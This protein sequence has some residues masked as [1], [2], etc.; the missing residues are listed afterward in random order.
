MT[1]VGAGGVSITSWRSLT[2]FDKEYRKLDPVVQGRVDKALSKLVQTPMPPGI[3]FEK[4]KGYQDP[5]IY[6]IH[7]TGNFKV[8]FEIDGS[9]AVLRRVAVHDDIDLNP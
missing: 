5:G 3:D 6:T 4:L 9:E 2:R 1:I 7:A 8:S